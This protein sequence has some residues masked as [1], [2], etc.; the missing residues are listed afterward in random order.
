MDDQVIEFCTG[1][2]DISATFITN[3]TNNTKKLNISFIHI[4][5]S[6]K[7][8][9]VLTNDSKKINPS[10][11]DVGYV[12]SE[13]RRWTVKSKSN[14]K[15]PKLGITQRVSTAM[16]DRILLYFDLYYATGSSIYQ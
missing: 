4:F 2:D 3:I 8:I 13:Y 16:Y 6:G 10:R 1:K 12:C 9:A 11:C 7:N 5:L 14:S 15:L